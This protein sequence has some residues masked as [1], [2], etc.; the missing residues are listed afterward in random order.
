MTAFAPATALSLLLF[1]FFLPFVRGREA[2]LFLSCFLAF[3]RPISFKYNPLRLSG[4]LLC[5]ALVVMLLLLTAIAQTEISGPVS[6]EW[7]RG[8]SR[9][10]LGWSL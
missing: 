6:G 4:L 1:A 3:L 2:R 8:N 5:T 7:T 10:T 9:L